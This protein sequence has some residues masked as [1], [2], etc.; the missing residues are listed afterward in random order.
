MVEWGGDK[1]R[2]TQG[3]C[4]REGKVSE[5]RKN[6]LAVSVASKL[7]CNRLNVLILY[8]VNVGESS[9]NIV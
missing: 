3:P 6:E 1:S 5:E 4:E 8:D 7:V 9:V 2:I